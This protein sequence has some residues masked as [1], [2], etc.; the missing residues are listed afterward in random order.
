MA[1]VDQGAALQPSAF[2][3]VN[4]PRAYSIGLNYEEGFGVATSAN[5]GYD[6]ILV[7]FTGLAGPRTNVDRPLIVKPAPAD[8]GEARPTTES[9]KANAGIDWFEKVHA[10]PRAKIEFGNIITQVTEEYE[11]YSAFRMLTIA[12]ASVTNNNEPGTD[13]P[14]LTLPQDV[15]PQTSILDPSTTGNP[16]PTEVLGTMVKLEL[17]AEQDGLPNFDGDIVFNF[18]AP[19]NSPLIS[20]SGKRLLLI[21][22]ECESPVEEVLAFLTDIIDAIDGK[23]K[24]SSLRESPRQEFKLNYKLSANDRQRMQALLMDWMDNAFGLPL[25]HEQVRLTAAVSPGATSYPVAAAD[26]VDFRVGGLAVVFTDANT[27]DVINITAKTSTTITAGDPSVN[28]Y[29][30]G[31]RLI[32]LRVVRIMRAVA[33]SRHPNNLEEFK[34]TFESDDNVTGAPTGDTTPG[35]WSI[36]NGKILFDDCNVVKGVMPETFERRI[37]RVDNATGKVTI[38]SNWGKYKRTAEKGI[39]AHNRAEIMSLRRALIAIGGKWKSFY[40]PTFIDDL[41][42]ANDLVVGT[43]IMDIERIEYQRLIA[44]RDPK[45]TFRI[46]FTDGTVLVRTIT[47][48]A[49]HPSDAT[50]ERLTVDSNWPADRTV[51][52]VDQVMFYEQVRFDTDR[53]TLRYPRIGLAELR[54]PVKA[55]FD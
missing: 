37:T 35:V 45:A 31:T 25:W 27:F 40:I 4:Q 6:A 55:V 3:P 47:A 26:E 52:E 34:C 53:F 50:L 19:A 41:T 49:D 17:V 21:T 10:L 23:E 1:G 48:S 30:A 36:Y 54:A 39:I 18:G 46:R 20:A 13:L 22:T 7:P 38:T 9:D 2:E 11:V 51:A 44:N 15:G 5:Q 33:G 28:G 32:P 24:R 14:N 8:S 12:L 42:V 16:G 29:V 43:N